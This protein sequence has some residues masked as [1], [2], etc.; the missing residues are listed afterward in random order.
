MLTYYE[1]EVYLHFKF[2][3]IQ[4]EVWLRMH[5]CLKKMSN[6]WRSDPYTKYINLSM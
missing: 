1:K 3:T 2:S 6:F 4:I 5:V